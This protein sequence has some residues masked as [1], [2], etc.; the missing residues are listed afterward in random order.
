MSKKYYEYTPNKLSQ[1]TDA[2]IRKEYSRLRSIANKRLMRLE[3]AGLNMTARTCYKF[4]TVQQ[5]EESSRATI[6][7][8]LADVSKFLRSERTTVKGEKQFLANFAES[9]INY[10]YGD[11]VETVDDIYK[12]IQ[13]LDDIQEDYTDRLYSSG[14]LLDVLQEAERLKIPHEKLKENLELFV[15]HLDELEKVKPTKGGRAFSSQRLKALIRK[16]S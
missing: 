7:S 10:G 3:K 14:D 11:I 9:M 6:A 13:F 5:I 16:W 4:P 12:T 2:A 15:S 1:M 8:G